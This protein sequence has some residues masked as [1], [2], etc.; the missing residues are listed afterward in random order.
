MQLQI[1]LSVSERFNL[2]L[3]PA[4][5]SA[6]NAILRLLIGMFVS[7]RPLRSHTSLSLHVVAAQP[8]TFDFFF[9]F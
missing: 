3:P 1:V 8:C 7:E 9:F 4:A 5:G 6:P 2:Q